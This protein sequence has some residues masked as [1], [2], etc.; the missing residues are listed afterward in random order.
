MLTTCLTETKYGYHMF[1]RHCMP[2]GHKSLQGGQCDQQ[3]IHDLQETSLGG[4]QWQ[5]YKLLT[6]RMV[7]LVLLT[8][9]DL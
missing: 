9:L 5:T 7:T 2:G 4:E 3:Q 6:T 1:G 8:Q